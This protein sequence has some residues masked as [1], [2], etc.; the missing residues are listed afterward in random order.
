MVPSF[1]LMLLSFPHFCNLFISASITS[2]S[3]PHKMPYFSGQVKNP[4]TFDSKLEKGFSACLYFSWS[5]L[6][7]HYLL[8][9]SSFCL[10][11]VTNNECLFHFFLILHG[12]CFAAICERILQLS[13]CRNMEISFDSASKV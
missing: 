8:F 7:C 10:P 4:C 1:S 5:S 2:V 12:K 9:F 3:A 13:R 6:T 11:C